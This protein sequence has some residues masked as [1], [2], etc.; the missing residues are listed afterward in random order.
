MPNGIAPSF[1]ENEDDSSV[2]EGAS[3]LYSWLSCS[4]RGHGKGGD[5][6]SPDTFSRFDPWS[7]CS[8]GGDFDDDN[9]G[10]DDCS[11]TVAE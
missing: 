1:D 6:S 4:G 11:N 9:R 5:D 7:S 10:E 2:S 8:N 3:G